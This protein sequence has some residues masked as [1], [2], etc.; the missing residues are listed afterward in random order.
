MW[1]DFI[2]PQLYNANLVNYSTYINHD[3]NSNS[4]NIYCKGYNQ[5]LN[6]VLDNKIL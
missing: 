4:I 3:S 6:N 2:N 5:K 1:N